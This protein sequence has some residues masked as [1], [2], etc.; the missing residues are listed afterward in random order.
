[1]KKEEKPRKVWRVEF[2]SKSFEGHYI[3]FEGMELFETTCESYKEMKHIIMLFGENTWVYTETGTIWTVKNNV[4][5]Y[6]REQ[7]LKRIINES[8]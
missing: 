4:N 7:K 1:M 8:D 5:N 6:F 2:K 3:E